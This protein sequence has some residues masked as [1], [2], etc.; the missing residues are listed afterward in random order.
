MTI[1]CARAADVSAYVDGELAGDA[2]AEFERHLAACATC[3]ALASRLQQLA[4]DFRMLPEPQLGFDLA[5]LI[6]ERLARE[7]SRA[8]TPR[9]PRWQPWRILPQALA[10]LA[11]AGAGVMM[12]VLVI[13]APAGA[14]G[15]PA[16][17]AVFDPIP[18]GGVC[19]ATPACPAAGPMQ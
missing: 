17:M 6:D 15:Q 5:A 13:G 1:P 3:A 2:L 4:T 19:L 8:K 18:P 11:S 12:G 7:Q 10:G 14:I 16:L 9:A